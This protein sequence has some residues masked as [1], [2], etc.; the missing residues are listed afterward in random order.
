M[1]ERLRRTYTIVSTETICKSIDIEGYTVADVFGAAVFYFAGLGEPE[2]NKWLDSYR[3]YLAKAQEPLNKKRT[4][5]V[6]TEVRKVISKITLQ[7]IKVQT[8]NATILH[9]F[10]KLSSEEKGRILSDYI[11][12]HREKKVAK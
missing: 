11:T 2:Q 5:Q 12:K 7:K 10:S 1:F 9:C 4:V 6:I 3:K 8:K